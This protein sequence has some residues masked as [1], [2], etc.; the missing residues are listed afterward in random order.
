LEHGI[1]AR[2]L[3]HH[4][5]DIFRAIDFVGR[6]DAR[7]VHQFQRHNAI[8]SLSNGSGGELLQFVRNLP[9]IG[10]DPV[11]EMPGLCGV[12]NAA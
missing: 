9:D 2:R 3:S 11:N 10:L 8:L 6:R 4:I 7:A 5:S 12:L 1:N